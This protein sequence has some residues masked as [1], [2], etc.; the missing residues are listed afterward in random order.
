VELTPAK[1]GCTPSSSSSGYDDSLALAKRLVAEAGIGLAPGMPLR[2]R[3]RVAA[4][5]FCVQDVARLRQG[6]DRLADWLAS[7]LAAQ[8]RR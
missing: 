1:G 3:R 5:V 7:R 8:R 6:V 2:R 4:V